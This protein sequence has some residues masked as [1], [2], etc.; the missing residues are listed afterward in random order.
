MYKP[1][2]FKKFTSRQTNYLKGNSVQDA[3]KKTAVIYVMCINI[4][5]I[6]TYACRKYWSMLMI[7]AKPYHQHQPLCKHLEAQEKDM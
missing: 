4:F 3:S 2:A 6:L 7:M 5:H 1:I